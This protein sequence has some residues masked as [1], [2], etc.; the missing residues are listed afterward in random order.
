M[1]SFLV[2]NLEMYGF[3]LI[4]KPILRFTK[5]NSGANLYNCLGNKCLTNKARGP[6]TTRTGS[7]RA[8]LT[9]SGNN[10][11]RMH[12]YGILE[13]SSYAVVK[14]CMARPPILVTYF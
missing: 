6:R 1:K 12:I 8:Y 7:S 2:V 9:A 14:T 5:L 3:H 4:I 13:L 10:F 11:A